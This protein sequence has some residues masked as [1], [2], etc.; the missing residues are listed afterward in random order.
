M[1]YRISFRARRG[2]V[3][4]EF[5]VDHEY[6]L[7]KGDKFFLEQQR[8]LLSQ[9]ALKFVQIWRVVDVIHRLNSCD[10]TTVEALPAM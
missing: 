3:V 10:L 5:V 2:G 8:E 4:A 1:K 9:E 6:P 7:H